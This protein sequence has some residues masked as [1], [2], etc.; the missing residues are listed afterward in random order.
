MFSYRLQVV[1]VELVGVVVFHDP[2]DLAD[3]VLGVAG[4]A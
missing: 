2:G 3:Q 4:P 1:A